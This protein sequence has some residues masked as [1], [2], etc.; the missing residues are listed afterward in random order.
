MTGWS[1]ALALGQLA[2]SLVNHCLLFPTA[3]WASVLPRQRMEVGR[4][5]RPHWWLEP[6]WEEK[7]ATQMVGLGARGGDV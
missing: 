6:V 2:P 5:G 7:A 3:P 1:W 4:A